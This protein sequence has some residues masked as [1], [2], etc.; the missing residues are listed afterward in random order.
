[1]SEQ[2]ATIV[3]DW[4]GIIA[5]AGLSDDELSKRLGVSRATIW[6]LRTGRTREPGYSLGQALLRI[7][8][9]PEPT[10]APRR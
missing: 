8:N 6:K 7:A 2:N 4:S 1:M 5:G 10:E 9:A 3:A